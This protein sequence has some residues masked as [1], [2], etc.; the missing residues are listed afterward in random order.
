MHGELHLE[1]RSSYHVYHPDHRC[2]RGLGLSLPINT[3]P[4]DGRSGSVPATRNE[5][6]PEALAAQHPTVGLHRLDVKDEEFVQ[7]LA[8]N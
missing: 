1:P 6:G 7:D 3:P 2:H 5:R 4:T 8:D